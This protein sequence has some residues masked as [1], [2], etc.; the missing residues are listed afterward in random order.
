MSRT[1]RRK[2]EKRVGKSHFIDPYI[3]TLPEE[4]NGVRAMHGTVGAFPSIPMEGKEYDKAYWWFHRDHHNRY[5]WNDT[6]G[7]KVCTRAYNKQELIKAIKDP[8]YVPNLLPFFDDKW[9][10]MWS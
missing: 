6:K 8:E 9:Y 5:M 10:W 7:S 4:W 1:I 2:K 3:N